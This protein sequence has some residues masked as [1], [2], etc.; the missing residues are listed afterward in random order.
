MVYVSLQENEVKP[1][2]KWAGGKNKI[3]EHFEKLYKLANHKRYFDLFCGSLS[4]PLLLKSN[5]ATF[6][7]INIW[8][9]NLYKVIKNELPSLKKELKQINKGKYNCQ[10]EFNIIRKKYNNLKQKE[11]ITESQKIEMAAIFIYLNKRSFNGLYR[12][13]QDG[14]YNVP[15]RRYKTNIYHDNEL[16]NLS[17]YLNNNKIKFKSKSYSKFKIETFKKGDLVYIDPPYYPCKKSNF[18]SYWK[19]PFIIDEQKKLAIYCKKLDK[20][21]IKFIVSN[22]P[23]PEIKD[24]YN[25]FNMKT[26]YIGRQMRSAEGKSDVF[27]KKNEDNEI[28][29]WNFNIDEQSD[30]NID[31]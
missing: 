14:K 28:L 15:Y 20:K 30:D 27:Q 18:T 1:V 21:G 3:I 4:L 10:E 12:E 2:I 11:D 6:N 17:K 29:I 13:N 26:F 19:T 22:A 7:D 23:C 5:K 25:D 8:L 16:D 31:V 24:L 9:I